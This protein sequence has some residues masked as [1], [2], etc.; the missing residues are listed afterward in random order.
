[1]SVELALG[2]NMN[3]HPTTTIILTLVSWTATEERAGL[4][5]GAKAE[6][7]ARSDRVAAIFILILI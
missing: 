6:A 7:V 1:M 4:E 5:A 2:H 3:C